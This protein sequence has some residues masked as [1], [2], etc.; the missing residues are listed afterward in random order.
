MDRIWKWIGWQPAWGTLVGFA[1]VILSFVLTA[2]DW[3]FIALAALGTFGPGILREM[4]LLN[5]QDEFQRRASRKAG[6]HAFLVAG[7]LSFFL[8]AYYRSTESILEEADVI[9]ELF[10]VILWFTWFFSSLLDYWGPAR[11]VTRILIAFGVFWALFNILGNLTDIVAL[12]MQTLLA[13]PFFLL[14]W[15]ATRWPRLAGILLILAAI[16]FFFMFDLYKIFGPDPLAKGRGHVIVL[17]FGPL[18]TSGLLLL[19]KTENEAVEEPSS[20]GEMS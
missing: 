6:Y 15:T 8:V 9:L 18:F 5:D 1:L 11:T 12:F 20:Q 19:K 4:G 16:S 2:V 17:F 14:A 10:L 7:L 13:V 3:A